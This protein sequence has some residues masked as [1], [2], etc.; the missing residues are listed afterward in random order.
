M[1][2]GII[3]EVGPDLGRSAGEEVVEGRGRQVVVGRHDHHIHLR[4]FAAASDSVDVSHELAAAL[5]AE[6]A[7]LPPD[8]W[9]RAV[10]YHESVAG[11][12]DR[13]RLDAVVADRPVR[14]Q[15]RSG[16]LW[17]LNSAA[18]QAAG[19]ERGPAGVERDE[20]GVPT[21]RV[22]REDSWLG[23]VVPRRPIDLARVSRT[24]AGWGITGLTE[25]TPYA[26]ADDLLQ[27]DEAAADGTI[28][29]R[30]HLMSGPG[31]GPVD[32]G[33]ATVGPVKVVLDDHR[34]PALDEL[35]T[36]MAA[37]HRAGRPV[38]V[39]CVTRAQAVLAV[40][41]FAADPSHLGDRIEHGAVIG[42][43]LFGPIRE[44]G[45][46]VVTQPGFVYARGDRYLAE[47]DAGDQPDLWRLGSLLHAG[48]AVVAGS[49]APFG[50]ADPAL[51]VQAATSRRTAGSQV[52][53]GA[54]AVGEATAWHLFSGSA[55][56]PQRPRTVDAGQPADLLLLD[57]LTTVI[58]G[59]VI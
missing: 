38:A 3:A 55:R 48:I 28:L 4:S 12:L 59:R 13:H 8:A 53:G 49:D 27:L 36:T 57:P 43:E 26:G 47:V 50:P 1:E 44:L 40:T 39:H 31:V 5:R 24:L 2:G 7:W 14:V 17:V 10:G 20:A 23:S 51:T 35:V 32:L 30:L 16:M 19:A 42:L 18:I 37:A 15:H 29:Q 22:W 46:T 54:E 21:G 41:A 6:D 56:H 45:L 33:A 11:D 58:A 25:A 52:V 9:I 34:L